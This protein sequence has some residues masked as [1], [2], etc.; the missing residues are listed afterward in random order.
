MEP[1][2]GERLEIVVGFD[3]PVYFFIFDEVQIRRFF[4]FT[5][6]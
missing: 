6:E 3:S 1:N 4:R 2:Q 5:L